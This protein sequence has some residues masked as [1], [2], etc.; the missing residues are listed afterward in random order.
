MIEFGR[1]T[2]TS[3]FDQLIYLTLWLIFSQSNSTIT[4]TEPAVTL[5]IVFFI[6]KLNKKFKYKFLIYQ[7]NN[8]HYMTLIQFYHQNN[9]FLHTL[10]TGC[11]IL[12]VLTT[13][14]HH[15]GRCTHSTGSTDWNHRVLKIK[16]LTG[17][18]LSKLTSKLTKFMFSTSILLKH[19][20][21]IYHSAIEISIHNFFICFSKLVKM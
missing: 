7:G 12:V 11:H 9:H 15:K 6:E 16:W 4:G 19:L 3:K 18:H 21:K 5:N 2:V 20:A 17:N 13:S 1:I 8:S 10:V 14:H